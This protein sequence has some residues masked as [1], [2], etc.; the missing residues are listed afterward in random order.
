MPLSSL[1]TLYHSELSIRCELYVCCLPLA[2]RPVSVCSSCSGPP[3][4]TCVAE[5]I[6]PHAA[7]S[8]FHERKEKYLGKG[9]VCSVGSGGKLRLLANWSVCFALSS[10]FNSL[11]FPLL[12]FMSLSFHCYHFVDKFKFA[13]NH[14]MLSTCLYTLCN[15]V[16]ALSFP[17]T[18]L[19]YSISVKIIPFL[20]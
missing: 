16:N 15:N 18:V 10:I 17:S 5:P 6:S 8:T 3:L 20:F 14:G 13:V 19:R 7:R 2:A 9:W 12:L 1:P 11:V 4:C